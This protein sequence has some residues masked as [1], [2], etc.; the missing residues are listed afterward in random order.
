MLKRAFASKRLGTMAAL[1]AFTALAVAVPT[2]V[3]DPAYRYD[4]DLRWWVH[5][6][7]EVA[8]L[9]QGSQVKRVPK[10]V[11]VRCFTSRKAFVQPFLNE[12]YTSS[13]AAEWVAYYEGGSVINMRAGTCR[14]A[15]EFTSGRVTQET[16]GAFSTLLHEAL[17][18]QGIDDERKTEGLATASMAAAGQLVEWRRRLDRGAAD[19]DAT[20]EASA[21]AGA[22]AARLAWQNSRLYSPTEYLTSW[23]KIGWYQRNQS[24]ADFLRKRH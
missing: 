23:P 18:R 15:H 19:D 2:A 20:W 8:S 14:V 17:H 1:A 12:G 6:S 10:E 11:Y 7:L 3:A 21:P 24:W 4:R 22:R 13:E 16:A 9:S 5:N